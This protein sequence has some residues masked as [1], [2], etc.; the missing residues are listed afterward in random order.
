VLQGKVSPY[1]Y[2]MLDFDSP[3]PGTTLFGL[4]D[5]FRT[6]QGFGSVSKPCTPGEHQNS[7]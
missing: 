7:W 1:H 4:L 6:L 3:F 5:S 2:E